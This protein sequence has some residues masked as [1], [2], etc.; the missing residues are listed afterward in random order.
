MGARRALSGCPLLFLSAGHKDPREMGKGGGFR[1]YPLP[2]PVPNISWGHSDSLQRMGRTR[3][4]GPTLTQHV[5]P[6]PLK[7]MFLPTK[8]LFN[9]L[10]GTQ[11][12][13]L[14]NVLMVGR[15]TE[16]VLGEI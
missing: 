12:Y 6:Q 13:N 15:I 3:E 4:S 16:C 2:N 9:S 10:V 11:L 7:H 14:K 8:V 5:C 1:I